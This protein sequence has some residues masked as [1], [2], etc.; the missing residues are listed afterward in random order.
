VKDKDKDTD[1]GKDKGKKKDKRTREQVQKDW[2]ASRK[3]S[4]NYW[5]CVKCLVR[6]YVMQSGWECSS[7][8]ASCEEDRR[9]ARQSLIPEMPRSE[10]RSLDTIDGNGQYQTAP[11]YS[12]FDTYS[13]AGWVQPLG[14]WTPPLEPQYMNCQP[15]AEQQ[16]NSYYGNTADSARD[17]QLQ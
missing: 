1:K 13:S 6:N 3:I 2:L 14:S 11:D 15:A 12:N 16:Y 10:V 8:K 5:R 7:C 9:I 17:W 4:E